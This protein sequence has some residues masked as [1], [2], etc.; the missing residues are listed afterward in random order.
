MGDNDEG[1]LEPED[2]ID[3][4]SEDGAIGHPVGPMNTTSSGFVGIPGLLFQPQTS[5]PL[6]NEGESLLPRYALWS[7]KYL[8]G[9][10]L[11]SHAEAEIRA[12]FGHGDSI[13]Y[14]IDDGRKNCFTCR[15]V[16]SGADGSVYCLVARIPYSAYDGLVDGGDPERIFDDAGSFS[17]C[18]VY[19][20]AES[21]SNVSVVESYHSS[22][23]VPEEYLPPSAPIAF[24]EN[25]DLP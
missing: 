17:L 7:M 24:G 8:R 11:F 4:I 25:D 18:V 14:V 2:D 20:D 15:K 19:D 13:V 22:A 10:H 9:S 12:V 23:E 21:V 5:T 6:D 3:Y 1:S 16:G